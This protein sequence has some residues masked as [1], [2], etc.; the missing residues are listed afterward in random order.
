MTDTATAAA[1]WYPDPVTPGAVRWWSG[2]AWTHETRAVAAPAVAPVDWSSLPTLAAEESTT[3]AATWSR[4][5]NL[6]SATPWAASRPRLA[7]S[8]QTAGGWMLALSPI[9]ANLLGSALV[10]V[11]ALGGIHLPNA[12]I[13]VPALVYVWIAGAL[14]GSALARRG[15][16]PPSVLWMLL[17]PPLVYLIVRGRRVRAARG[18]AW[19]IE[20][21]YFLQV[22]IAIILVVLAIAT[23]GSWAGA[24]Y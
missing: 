7:D 20:L 10:T 4:D 3:P 2:A 5:P 18:T 22:A 23:V 8:A 1:G 12:V 6:S 21:V 11:L 16:R 15:Y 13:A 14:D 9:A 24:P 19:P 17:L